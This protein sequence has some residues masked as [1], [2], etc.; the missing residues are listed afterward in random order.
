MSKQSGEKGLRLAVFISGSGSNLQA[1]IDAQERGE[2]PGVEIALVVSNK[3]DAYGLQR[4][5]R[6]K[7]PAI[8]LPWTKR[9]QQVAAEEKLVALLDLF[10][11]DLIVLAGWMRI[12]TPEFITRYPQRIINQHPALLPFD[13]EGDTCILSDG[14]RIP[15]LRGLHVVQR[16][17]DAGLKTTGCVVH[18]VIPEVD[19]GRVICQTEVPVQEG[20]DEEKLYERIKAAEHRLIVE[21]VRTCYQRQH[22]GPVEEINQ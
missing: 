14:S 20:D 1:L 16:A 4:A 9:S 13:G 5:L 8:Y 12:F 6:H 22:S 7:L 18:Y 10:K 17:L 19:A 11:I 2:M 21:A 3:A 15:A